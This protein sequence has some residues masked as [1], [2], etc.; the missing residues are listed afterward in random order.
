MVAACRFTGK[1]PHTAIPLSVGAIREGVR[2]MG[3]PLGER[4]RPDGLPL[5]EGLTPSGC[6]RGSGGVGGGLAGRTDT[7]TNGRKRGGK[8]ASSPQQGGDPREGGAAPRGRTAEGA[9]GERGE[10]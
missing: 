10:P 7:H 8:G 3:T 4:A 2:P 6:A 5:R 9:R 1:R